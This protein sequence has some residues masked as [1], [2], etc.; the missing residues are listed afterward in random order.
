MID[1][2]GLQVSHYHASKAFYLQALKPLGYELVMEIKT[3]GGLGVDGVPEFW[4]IEG[5]ITKPS[6]HIALRAQTRDL[7]DAFHKAALSAGGIDNGAPGIR[8][9]HPHYYGAFIRDP[10]GHNIEAVCHIP[11]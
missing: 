1:H 9:Y 7:V 2:I 6:V 5:E 10:D 8:S 11:A 3:W 4:I